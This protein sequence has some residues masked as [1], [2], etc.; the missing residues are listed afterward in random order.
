MTRLAACAAIVFVAA[1]SEASSLD[2]VL[3]SLDQ[4]VRANTVYD[5]RYVR[6]GIAPANIGTCI[7]V[8]IRAYLTIGVD[9]RKA[10]NGDIRQ[11]RKRYRFAVPDPNIDHRRCRNTIVYM[12]RFW[13]RIGSSVRHS[14]LRP[15]DVVYWSTRNNGI[16]DHVGVVSRAKTATGNWLI[17]HHWP[18]QFVESA[19]IL[20]SWRVL[21]AYRLPTKPR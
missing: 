7:D 14:D 17:T 10:V 16:A 1:T 4:Q 6:G 8:V 3:N 15:G 11:N 18:G 21:G 12:N 9:L 13:T 5:A 19:D 20:D 2:K